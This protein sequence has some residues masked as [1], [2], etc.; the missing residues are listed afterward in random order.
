MFVYQRGG[1]LY[2]C[3]Q[4]KQIGL[5]HTKIHHSELH[6]NTH[7]NMHMYACMHVCVCLCV[8]NIITGGQFYYFEV[9]VR[10]S[11]T[12]QDLVS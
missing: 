6:V 1:V 10:L 11:K 4:K 5:C 8:V 2:L 3:A 9:Q 7:I 12:T